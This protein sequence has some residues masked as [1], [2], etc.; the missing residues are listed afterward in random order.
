MTIINHVIC[1]C[2][3]RVHIS[4]I[5]SGDELTSV[6]LYEP[7]TLRLTVQKQYSREPHKVGWLVGCKSHG[8]LI[9][10]LLNPKQWHLSCLSLGSRVSCQIISSNWQQSIISMETSRTLLALFKLIKQWVCRPILGLHFRPCSTSHTD[11]LGLCL[12]WSCLLH[13]F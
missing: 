2:I 1:W 12:A 8:R 3:H 4:A 13:R 11:W 9:F 7:L 5:I 10:P 6:I